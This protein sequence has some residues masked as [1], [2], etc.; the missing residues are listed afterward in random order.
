MDDAAELRIDNWLRAFG[1]SEH[2][3]SETEARHDLRLHEYFVE[4]SCF[5]TILGTA[6]AP[7][8]AV[9][10]APQ[11]G[12]KTANCVMVDH[13]CKTNERTRG[14]VLSIS[15]TNFN[16][17]T[18]LIAWDVNGV[19]CSIN[20]HHH[21]AE[22]LKQGV[23]EVVGALE[24][25]RLSVSVQA[26][27]VASGA[28]ASEGKSD[29]NVHQFDAYSFYE[30]GLHQLRNRV[31]DLPRYS[32]FLV[33]QQRLI[34]NIGQSRRYGDIEVRKA[35]RSEIVDRL[36]ELSLSVLDMPFT[37]LLG[38]STPTTGQEPSEHLRLSLDGQDEFIQRS[39]LRI[40]GAY[41][42]EGTLRRILALLPQI[43]LDA[44]EA[45]LRLVQ[46]YERSQVDGTAPLRDFE[47]LVTTLVALGMGAVYVLV[48]RI[49]EFHPV[50]FDPMAGA[51]FL[52]PLLSHLSLL[53][54]EHVAFKF[55]LP[56]HLKSVLLDK[57][58]RPDRLVVQEITWSDE[59]LLETLH[60]RLYVFSE[61]Q[62]P[63][64]APLFFSP[65]LT[66]EE[67]ER[68][69]VACAKGSPRHLVLLCRQ[70]FATHVQDFL[71]GDELR[72]GQEALDKAIDIFTRERA[73]WRPIPSRPLGFPLHQE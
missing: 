52:S 72:I 9:L 67:A 54:M 29:A 17:L 3:F 56:S 33:Y 45:R 7:Q 6:A 61:R 57:G 21:V 65:Q 63:T 73:R 26:V 23:V 66:P 43:G 50:S 34:E 37:G 16:N 1:F 35:E 69:L 22:I 4:P 47:V 70:L 68:R 62:V 64:L 28:S 19:H 42:D 27:D 18:G 41:S 39:L 51:L 71:T 55:F 60:S 48:D 13:F 24:A 8:S 12:G 59:D 5:D 40:L 58:L 25:D 36:N 2:P 10:F 53:E 38:L 32:E 31:K 49:D 11:G 46:A 30:T 20:V 14:P 44:D 15:Y